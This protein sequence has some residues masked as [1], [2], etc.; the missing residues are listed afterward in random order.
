VRLDYPREDL[1]DGG[2]RLR[3]WGAADLGCVREA[4]TDPRIPEWTT[5]PAAFT[6]EEGLAFI[7]RQWGRADGGEG[8]S[9]AL[10][11]AATGEAMGLIVLLLEPRRPGVAETGYWVIPRA[12]G[13]GNATRAVRLVSAWALGDAGLA[14]VQ[15]LVEPENEASQRVLRAAGFQPE[16]VLRSYL[17]TGDRRADAVVFSRI[18]RDL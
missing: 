3:R 14:R 11:D 10:A 9:F 15:A 8:L 7:R 5:V 6:A 16:G 12:R 13:R 2:V 4:T 1:T 17:D 18:T